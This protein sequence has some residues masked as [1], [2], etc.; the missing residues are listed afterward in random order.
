MDGDGR[1]PLDHLARAYCT[2]NDE[3]TQVKLITLIKYLTK[4]RHGF[5]A[6]TLYDFEKPRS[7]DKRVCRGGGAE[8]F[9]N[10]LLIRNES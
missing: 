4:S 2:Q 1:T 3:K 8:V 7:M 6:M 9:P 10:D 5:I